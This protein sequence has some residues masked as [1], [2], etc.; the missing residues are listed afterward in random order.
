[1]TSIQTCLFQRRLHEHSILELLRRPLARNEVILKETLQL[2]TATMGQAVM[3][4]YL[5]HVVSGRENRVLCLGIVNQV[6]QAHGMYEGN[7]FRAVERQ[8]VL[9]RSEFESVGR[10]QEGVDCMQDTVRRVYVAFHDLCMGHL[11]LAI[12]RH[13][14]KVG[15]LDSGHWVRVSW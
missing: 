14:F 11:D 7:E 12:G 13:N 6:R 8:K 1:M 4:E 10:E 15:T 9:L 3:C 5:D 2:F